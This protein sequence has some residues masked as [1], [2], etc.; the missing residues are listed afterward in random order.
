MCRSRV[1]RCI[2]GDRLAS[3]LFTS[4][5][6][7]V[8]WTSGVALL[9]AL[10]YA[11]GFV[12]TLVREKQPPTVES[13]KIYR[14]IAPIHLASFLRD[15]LLVSLL[16]A[17]FLAAPTV[18]PHDVEPVMADLAI[19]FFQ[20]SL[21]ALAL[22]AAAA[23]YGAQF[24]DSRVH[25]DNSALDLTLRTALTKSGA[26]PRLDWYPVGV[27][28]GLRVVEKLS[29]HPE[30]DF[31]RELQE[32]RKVF[33]APLAMFS[34]TAKKE[35]RTV[36]EILKPLDRE[37][38][39]ALLAKRG[40]VVHDALALAVSLTERLDL[41]RRY[42]RPLVVLT[43]AT[44]S[45]AWAPFVLSGIAGQHRLGFLTAMTLL[46]SWAVIE[47]IIAVLRTLHWKP[48]NPVET[49]SLVT[50]WVSL[51]EERSRTV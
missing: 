11:A 27:L 37:G 2:P 21:T 42:S 31:L 40:Q 10:F 30:A 13:F 4:L 18:V 24:L 23:L 17:A 47:V 35:L 28:L 41:R 44:L 26:L 3:T 1:I 25:T 8:L 45:T 49:H 20:G 6:P 48:I 36:R 19:G 34:Q 38:A 15:L 12:A 29:R 14:A 7:V 22:I 50:R 51:Q 46:V 5:R 32:T 43:A 39:Q 33:D 9:A 16:P